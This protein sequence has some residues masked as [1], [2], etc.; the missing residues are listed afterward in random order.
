[1]TN[2]WHT[3][4]MCY[5]HM[6]KDISERVTLAPPIWRLDEAVLL[7]GRAVMQK[8]V[9]YRFY[10]VRMYRSSVKEW[11]VS[12]FVLGAI[13]L[14]FTDTVVCKYYRTVHTKRLHI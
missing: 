12:W 7:N 6:L 14:N 10:V 9:V 11:Q 2:R 1:M 5:A 8:G 4:T 3:L 13:T